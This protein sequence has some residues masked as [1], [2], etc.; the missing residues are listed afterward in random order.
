SA[1]GSI[2]RGRLRSASLRPVTLSH[3]AATVMTDF[4]WDAPVTVAA[5]RFI[6]EALSDMIIA[7]VRALLV[8]SR[9]AVERQLGRAI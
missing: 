8:F 4:T 3:P 6:D 1:G 5:D 9:T 2:D 7:G